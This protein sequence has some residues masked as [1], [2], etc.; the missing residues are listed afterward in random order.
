MGYSSYVRT[1]AILYGWHHCTWLYTYPQYRVLLNG[2][3]KHCLTRDSTLNFQSTFQHKV[4]RKLKDVCG[5]HFAN[6]LSDPLAGSSGHMYLWM[7]AT[8]V[9]PKFIVDKWR[10]LLRCDLL[11][12]ERLIL[13]TTYVGTYVHTYIAEYVRI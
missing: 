7:W 13:C 4:S 2:C 6:P 12:H 5:N 8:M 1:I 9:L 11:L 10:V 3:R